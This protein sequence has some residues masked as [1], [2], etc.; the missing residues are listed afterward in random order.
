MIDARQRGRARRECAE[1][2]RGADEETRVRGPDRLDEQIETAPEHHADVHAGVCGQIERDHLG[3][4]AGENFA[5]RGHHRR[6]GGAAADGADDRAVF[7]AHQQ[8]GC[9]VGRNGADD[10]DDGRQRA[11][12]SRVPFPYEFFIDVHR[13]RPLSLLERHASGRLADFGALRG[14][15][16]ALAFLALGG[17]DLEQPCP[18]A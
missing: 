9:R 11:V 6:L 2:A 5:S 3:L 10:V 16:T 17:V 4:A 18:C 15:E 12:A 7:V 13:L 8:L 1:R 14:V